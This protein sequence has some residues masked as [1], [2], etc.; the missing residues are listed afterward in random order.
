MPAA[1]VA[2]P[3]PVPPAE[4]PAT[5]AMIDFRQG[6]LSIHAQNSSLVTILNQVSRQTGLVVEGLNHDQR[7]YGQ[8]GPGN[9]AS[10]LTA[11]LDGSG[12]NYVIVGGDSSH[13][14]SKLI[15][16][17]GNAP[18]AP[19]VPVAANNGTVTPTDTASEPV[20]ANPSEP[21]QAKT[22]QEIFDELRKMHPR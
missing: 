20:S 15:L 16:T 18:S 14:P 4:Q 11:L 17:Q 22:P 9:M 19:G 7:V 6:L 12:Y 5:Q 3:R 21:V 2:P 13:A 1:P 10:T 8:Y